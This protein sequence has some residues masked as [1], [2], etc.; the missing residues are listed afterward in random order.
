MPPDRGVRDD[1][2]AEAGIER[3]DVGI[4]IGDRLEPGPV[5]WRRNWRD[6]LRRL[7]A[8]HGLQCSGSHRCCQK[9]SPIHSRFLSSEIYIRTET[10]YGVAARLVLLACVGWALWVYGAMAAQISSTSPQTETF[11]E[12]LKAAS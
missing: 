2:L 6:L 9:R 8:S 10:D 12:A 7:R 3:D 11:A 1:V 5:A 4:G